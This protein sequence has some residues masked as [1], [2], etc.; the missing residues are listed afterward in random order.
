MQNTVHIINSMQIG[1][2]E[3]GALSL[4]KSKLS[5]NY[6]LIAVKGCDSKL[7]ELLSAEEKSRFYFCS[8]Y[9]EAL[10]L[11]FKLKPKLI[12]SSLWRAHFMSLIFTIFHRN[13]KRIHFVHNSRFAHLIDE[14]IT[15]VSTF[16]ADLVVC[17]SDESRNWFEKT[18]NCD[19][20]EVIP[21]NVSFSK[22]KKI[23]SFS[24]FSFVYVGRYSIQKNLLKSI[25]FIEKLNT[26]GISCTFDLYGRDDGQ[27]QL[28]LD[29]V[30]EHELDNIIMFNEPK[31]PTEIELEMQKYNYYL[32]TSTA[33]GMAIS[34]YQAISNGLL[35]VVTP[36]GEISSY[37]RDYVNAVHIDTDNLDWSVAHFKKFVS[38]VEANDS[39][40]GMIINAEKYSCFDESFFKTINEF[41]KT[42]T[43]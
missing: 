11:L 43:V 12:V 32:Q 30:H 36:V 14:V 29:Y 24:P 7:Y 22:S 37:T 41:K 42:C 38:S 15:R 6:T 3:V 2:V 16:F 35:P 19:K 23:I 26:S 20:S 34:V 17:D 8:G 40:V 5:N 28:L 1:G 21:M 18:M 25:Q 4:L 13:S 39:Q 33:E 31:L 10:K 9:F 27:K